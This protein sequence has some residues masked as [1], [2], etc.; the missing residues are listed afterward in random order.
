[1]SLS[2]LTTAWAT[3]DQTSSALLDCA[4]SMLLLGV[5]AESERHLLGIAA[6][7]DKDGAKLAEK[8]SNSHLKVVFRLRLEEAIELSE[9]GKQRG[10]ETYLATKTQQD[11][12]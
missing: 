2:L 11:G 10:N 1:M 4:L 5:L 9:H 3:L 7:F 6:D 8:L 12:G